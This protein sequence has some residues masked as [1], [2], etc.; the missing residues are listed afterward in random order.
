MSRLVLLLLPVVVLGAVPRAVLAQD[1]AAPI[2]MVCEGIRV[3]AVYVVRA[4]KR[5]HGMR[6]LTPAWRKERA[7]RRSLATV[8]QRNGH[9][10]RNAAPRREADGHGH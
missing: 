4:I 5:V 6:L 9:P 8:P 1:A 10:V 7:R 2:A 3:G